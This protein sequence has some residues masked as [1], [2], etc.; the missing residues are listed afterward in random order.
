MKKRYFWLALVSSGIIL[1][2]ILM[3]KTG[4][5]LTNFMNLVILAVCAYA[6][7]DN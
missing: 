4:V 5:S 7:Y 1:N 2:V 6:L 3:M